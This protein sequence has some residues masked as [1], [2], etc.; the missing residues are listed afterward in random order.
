MLK[1][2]KN[3]CIIDCFSFFAPIFA[4]EMKSWQRQQSKH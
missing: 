4:A 3:T 2:D 1:R